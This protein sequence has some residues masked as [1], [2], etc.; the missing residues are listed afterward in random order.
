ML[1]IARLKHNLLLDH[2]FYC[3]LHNWVLTCLG[4][5]VNLGRI[6]ILSKK[7]LLSM[8]R[9]K[10]FLLSCKCPT[11]WLKGGHHV[12]LGHVCD[13]FG[14][15]RYWFL[16][17]DYMLI[18][19][20]LNH[21]LLCVLCLFTI[22]FKGVHDTLATHKRLC[23]VMIKWLIFRAIPVLRLTISRK[24]GL[25]ICRCWGDLNLQ[26][27]CRLLIVINYHTRKIDLIKTD[28][29]TLCQGLTV[30]RAVFLVVRDVVKRRPCTRLRLMTHASARTHLSNLGLSIGTRWGMNV[31]SVLLMRWTIN[32]TTL[33]DHHIWTTT[34]IVV[35]ID[36][37][38]CTCTMSRN[39][40]RWLLCLFDRCHLFFQWNPDYIFGA[41]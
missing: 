37:S 36:S 24:D 3:P 5:L 2:V 39:L 25:R 12:H 10:W 7:L 16:L 22:L 33:D 31:V 41:E 28:A 4:L 15:V 18:S 26:S 17:L 1:C 30:D 29:R 21:L 34:L 20:I 11:R 13:N 32:Y 27:R 35:V 14:I 6:I 19:P 9:E 23:F 8:L 40:L 38:V